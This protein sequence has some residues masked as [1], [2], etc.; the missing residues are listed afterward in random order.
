MP[1]HICAPNC[2]CDKNMVPR[3]NVSVKKRSRSEIALE[4]PKP[5]NIS[6][7]ILRK[8]VS[9]SA[10]FEEKSEQDKESASTLFE[11]IG[12]NDVE[13]VEARFERVFKK[14]YF[15]DMEILGQFNL[16]F[17]VAR[18]G[19]DL[20]ILDQHACDEKF[21]FE[22][23]HRNAKMHSQRLIQPRTLHV[24]AQDEMVI[25]EHADL[26][27]KSGF[28]IEIDENAAVGKRVKIC[29]LSHCMGAALRVED[30]NEYAS[31]LQ[32]WTSVKGSKPPKLPKLDRLFASR[33]CR[34]SVMIGMALDRRRMTSI[35]RNLESLDQP[36]NCPHG[37]PTMR[38]LYDMRCL[39]SSSSSSNG[40]TKKRR[41]VFSHLDDSDNE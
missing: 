3:V 19:H 24:S 32:D 37:R 12:T 13:N 15:R 16:G 28:D 41:R 35:V 26:F 7:E 20:F 1:V 27:R 36:W 30:L 40:R 5:M 14:R 11:G 6:L 8:H 17:I 34:S 22:R 10:T 18:L 21:N 39:K 31:V 38:H 9:A 33:A 25:I 23:L 29:G 4:P 2:N